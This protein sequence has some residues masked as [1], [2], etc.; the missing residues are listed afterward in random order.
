MA[1]TKGARK[2]VP[3]I[4]YSSGSRSEIAEL[5]SGKGL[6]LVSSLWVK[7]YAQF[8]L[9]HDITWC[10]I[11]IIQFPEDIIMMQE[12]IWKIRPDVIIECGLAHGGAAIFYASL[13]ELIGHGKVIGIDIEIN[14]PPFYI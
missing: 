6:D 3:R 1:K 8:K 12:L 4:Q 14:R 10:G 5:Y 7:L 11:P 9:T 2:L 13:L